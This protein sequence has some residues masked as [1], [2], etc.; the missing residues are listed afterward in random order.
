MIDR[1]TETI[2][3]SATW[4][5]TAAPLLI[6]SRGIALVPNLRPEVYDLVRNVALSG[7]T[8]SH[9]LATE[10]TVQDDGVGIDDDL[11]EKIYLGEDET[12]PD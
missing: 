6:V 5:A 1:K 3:K 2:D 8:E 12:L 9:R 10:I 7:Q 11:K 4:L